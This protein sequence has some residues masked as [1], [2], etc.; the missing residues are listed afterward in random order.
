MHSCFKGMVI[1][2][3]RCWAFVSFYKNFF[4]GSHICFIKTHHQKNR[5]DL[6]I[7]TKRKIQISLDHAGAMKGDK[8]W[9]KGPS[10][11]ECFFY[12]KWME[13][14]LSSERTMSN[15][16]GQSWMRNFLAGNI[17]SRTQGG[18][19][20]KVYPNSGVSVSLKFLSSIYMILGIC[21][22]LCFLFLN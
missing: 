18:L 9:S 19:E 12:A 5:R 13:L 17:E 10:A 6:S 7:W 15:A 8:N 22:N 14:W 11:A 1:F 4:D 20:P 21:E 16:F 2:C 3:F